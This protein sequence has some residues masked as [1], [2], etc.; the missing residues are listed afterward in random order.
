[1]IAS[2]LSRAALG[3]AALGLAACEA[4]PPPSSSA[5]AGLTVAE[6]EAACRDAL[7][8]FHSVGDVRIAGSEPYQGGG[9]FVRGSVRVSAA[10]KRELW[11]C[12]AYADG[13]T[14]EISYLA[15]DTG[16]APAGGDDPEAAAR[17]ACLRDVAQ[18]TGNPIVRVQS[19]SFS[20]AGTEVIVLVGDGSEGVPPAPWRCIAYRD[21]ST[22]GIQF[23]GSEG[24]L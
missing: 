15:D 21:G 20:E 2:P 19:S 9:R 11:Q 23:L 3:L 18:E 8:D 6:A 5:P 13:S 16:G 22:A 17:Q 1:M 10:G 24:A 4:P 7:I 12:I 14:G